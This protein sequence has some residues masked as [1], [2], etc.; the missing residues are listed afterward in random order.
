MRKREVSINEICKKLEVSRN[1][2]RKVIR[3][4]HHDV[5][6]KV[7]KYQP[8]IPIIRELYPICKKN[9]VRLREVLKEKHN[10]FIPYPSLVW[11]L[12][13]EG[14]NKSRKKQ[15]GSYSFAPGQESQH[16]TSPYKIMLGDKKT[17]VQ[18]ASLVLAHSRRLY[19]QFYPRYTR[20]EARIFLIE[21]LKFMDGS[22][23]RCIIDNTSVLVARGAGPNAEIT[24]QIRQLGNMFGMDFI[25]HNVG[26][27]DR[28]ARVERAFYYVE[29]NFLAGRKYT[30]WADLNKQAL[31]WC[32]NV[33]NQKPKRSLGMS[34]EQAYIMEKPSLI[35]L[36]AYIPP[37]YMTE[38]RV[39]D[40]QG[41]VHLDT[42][43]YSVPYKLIGE[44]V[45]VQKHK[46]HILI[47]HA[48][49]KITEHKREITKKD[50]RIT[51]PGHK[52]PYLKQK[53]N[54]SSSMEERMLTG[55]N[56]ILDS[57]IVQLKKR[58]HG[59]GVARFRK[60][61]GIKRT[62]PEEPFM[63]GIQQA[64]RYG[65][66]DLARL[67]KIIISFIAGEFFDL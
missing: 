36:P 31:A 58:S 27:P 32:E 50:F 14:L 19:I 53:S 54:T 57:Y 45:E 56:Q 26:H 20:F 67:E 12:R 1:T 16:D 28:K 38:Y 66:Y 51:L 61:L 48:N 2:V 33:A 25:P 4:Q 13:Q 35:P 46:E 17:T 52:A 43:R 55:E 34:P 47:Y 22:C 63:A 9:A 60:L 62:Y 40:I 8:H 15:S 49:K 37:V 6:S 3:G 42:N 59:R 7:S 18:C 24:P 44:K 41:Y 64:G 10:I 39:V 30:D 29:R 65:L 23:S 21:A 5:G 11:L